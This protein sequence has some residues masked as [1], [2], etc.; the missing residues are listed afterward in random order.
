M[1]VFYMLLLNARRGWAA[2]ACVCVLSVPPQEA[3]GMN[4]GMNKVVRLAVCSALV[5][6]ILGITLHSLAFVAAQK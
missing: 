3:W 5:R 2:C 1:Y 6:T 4:K